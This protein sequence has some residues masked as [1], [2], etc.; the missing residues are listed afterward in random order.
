M[1]KHRPR[2]DCSLSAGPARSV[3][4]RVSR[5]RGASGEFSGERQIYAHTLCK[6]V[7]D[8]R[9]RPAIS[10]RTIAS[11]ASIGLA[12]NSVRI[13]PLR[14]RP[15]RLYSRDDRAVNRVEFAGGFLHTG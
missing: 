13:R 7:M 5:D 2:A 12:G 14:R 10:S 6:N 15:S 3:P 1:N 8:R 4:A 9:S 11:G